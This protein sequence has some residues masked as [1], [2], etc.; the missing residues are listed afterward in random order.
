MFSH[1][2]LMYLVTPDAGFFGNKVVESILHLWVCWNE[3]QQIPHTKS[4]PGDYEKDK[5]HEKVPFQM[6]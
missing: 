6:A 4:D 1:N 5:K 2:G 3:Q